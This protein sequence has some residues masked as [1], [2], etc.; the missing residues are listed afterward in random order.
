MQFSVKNAG[1]AK[2]IAHRMQAHPISD[3]R[4]IL[5][6]RQAGRTLPLKSRVYRA[7]RA[8]PATVKQVPCC[9]GHRFGQDPYL[10]EVLHSIVASVGLELLLGLRCRGAGLRLRCLGLGL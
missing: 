9:A 6:L 3:L 5:T 10:N 7:C 4:Q 1:E 8:T 2:A